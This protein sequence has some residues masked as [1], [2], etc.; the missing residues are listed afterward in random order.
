M[1]KNVNFKI[2]ISLTEVS[3][4]LRTILLMAEIS[5]GWISLS[6]KYKHCKLKEVMMSL[7]GSNNMEAST[8]TIRSLISIGDK[9]TDLYCMSPP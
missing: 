3:F 8:T 7:H 2:F 5:V 4:Y 1:Y 9:C 6:F